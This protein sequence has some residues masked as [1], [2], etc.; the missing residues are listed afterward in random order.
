MNLLEYDLD[1]V[2]DEDWKED[3]VD[4]PSIKIDAYTDYILYSVENSY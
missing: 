4:R 3:Q 2:V 1:E